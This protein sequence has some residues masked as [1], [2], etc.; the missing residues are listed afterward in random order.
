[1]KSRSARWC[2]Y[3]FVLC[4]L[5]CSTASVQAMMQDQRTG[6]VVQG[7]GGPFGYEHVRTYW[8]DVGE[9]NSRHLYAGPVELI[10]ADARSSAPTDASPASIGIRIGV[11]STSMKLEARSLKWRW[12]ALVGVAA[13]GLGW[14]RRRM[15][16][17]R[18][19][20]KET[21]G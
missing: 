4:W 15:R 18:V 19:P 2:G 6:K 12:V 9:F 16:E 20:A 5:V 13:V 10:L 7:P 17:A 14:W 1:M 21:E 11:W 3:L 8:S